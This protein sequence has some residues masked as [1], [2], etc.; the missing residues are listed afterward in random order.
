LK[1]E[2]VGRMRKRKEKKDEDDEI[3]IEMSAEEPKNA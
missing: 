3:Y 2:D 1:E